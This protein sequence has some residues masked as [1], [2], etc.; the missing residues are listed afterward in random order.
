MQVR[1]TLERNP[2]ANEADLRRAIEG[3]VCRCTGY[4]KVVEAALA[5]AERMRGGEAP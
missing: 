1:N 2:A 5:A 4:A 3:T